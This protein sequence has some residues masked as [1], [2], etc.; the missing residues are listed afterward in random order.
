MIS[1][2]L[3]PTTALY[4]KLSAVRLRGHGQ[5]LAYYSATFSLQTVLPSHNYLRP[6]QNYVLHS[7]VERITQLAEQ[8]KTEHSL[9]IFS[10]DGY[11]LFRIGGGEE[12]PLTPPIVELDP[13]DGYIVCDGMHRIYAAKK[14]GVPIQCVVVSGHMWPYYAHPTEG[15]WD[16]V[17][18]IETLTGDYKRKTYREPDDYKVLFRDFNAV[19]PGIQK[20]R[21]KTN[22]GTVVS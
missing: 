14:M 9:N 15:G 12:I 3:K 18:E 17:E 1:Y 11:L 13:S 19:F 8:F 6:S 10:L 20:E 16:A 7:G 22:T 5:P 4:N 21:V 2:E